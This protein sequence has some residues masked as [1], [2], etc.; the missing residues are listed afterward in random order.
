MCIVFLRIVYFLATTIIKGT[1]GVSNGVGVRYSSSAPSCTAH[2][3]ALR[4]SGRPFVYGAEVVAADPGL[5][6][7]ITGRY[8]R[9]TLLASLD[10]GVIRN[11]TKYR[12]HFVNDL[13]LL[14]LKTLRLI[15][16]RRKYLEMM[17]EYPN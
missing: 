2:L 4:Y 12:E 7:A 5:L 14:E 6:L 9:I 11:H 16:I 17:A 13:L 10:Y 15:Q 8:R 3:D 1:P